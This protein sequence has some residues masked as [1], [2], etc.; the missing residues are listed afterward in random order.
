MRITTDDGVGL[1]VE[2]L[3]SGPPFLMVH[4]FTGA[5]E[6]LGDHA[7]RFAEHSRVVRFDHR[8]HGASDKPDDPHGYTLDRLVADT[9]AVADDLGLGQFAL[10]GHSMGGM[11]ARR[12]VLAH[13]E[14]VHSLVLMGTSPGMPPSIDPELAGVAADVALND[15]MTVL[16]TILDDVDTLGSEADKRVQRERPGYTEFNARKW[17]A[18]A[19]AAYAG[20]MRSMIHQPDQIARMHTITCPTLVLVGEEDE[21]FVPAAHAMIDVLLDS[22]LVVVPDAGHSPQFESPDAYFAAVEEHLRRTMVTA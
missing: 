21:H 13:P 15:G 14:R 2:E 17:A 12:L 3:G 11:V 7:P 10:L 16:R 5:K 4:G 20:L 1:A 8:G 19:P 18:V 9:L 6:D 22:R